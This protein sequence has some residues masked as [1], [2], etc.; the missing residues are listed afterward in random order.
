MASR[1]TDAVFCGIFYPLRYSSKD[2]YGN[3]KQADNQC[4]QQTIAV[5]A[6]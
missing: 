5:M 2:K 4:A 3:V 6:P 1:L